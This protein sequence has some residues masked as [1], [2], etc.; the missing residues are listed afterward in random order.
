MHIDDIRESGCSNIL[1]WAIANGADLKNDIQLQALINDQTF[2]LVTVSDISFLEVFRLSQIYREKLRVLNEKRADI[3]G[4][5]E[6]NEMFS[7][8]SIEQEMSDGTKTEVRLTE[9]AEYSAQQFLNLAIQMQADDDI[10]RPETTRLFIPMLCRRFDVQVPVSFIDIISGL[11]TE[12]EVT[13]LFN[14]DYPDNLHHEV[15]DA[16]HSGVRNALYMG[17]LKSTSIV[18]YQPHYE[19]LIKMVKYSHLNKVKSDELYKFRMIGFYKYDNISHGEVRCDMFQ[20]N[21]SIV[22]QNMKRLAY[23]NTPLKVE[24]VIQLP[25]QY[26][27]MILA[28]FSR[29]ELA[30]TYESSMSSIIDAGISF[31]DFKSHEFDEESEDPDVQAKITE[32]NNSIAAYETRI[33]EANQTTLNAISMLLNSEKDVDITSV[34]ALLPAIYNAKAVITIDSSKLERYQ[35]FFSGNLEAMF[36]EMISVVKSLITDINGYKNK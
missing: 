17:L 9:V 32:Y 6:M 35:Q 3:P 19:Q 20:P 1:K 24:F 31:H 22:A 33:T 15:I 18:R 36:T 13:S 28:S 4:V 8:D 11:Q 23:I 7:G 25:I 16:E 5:N 34:F 10:I 27:Q 29:E 2:Y 30:V 21:K 26:M 14:S 12:E